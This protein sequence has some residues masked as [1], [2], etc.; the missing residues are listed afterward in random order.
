MNEVEVKAEKGERAYEALLK[1]VFDI[2]TAVLSLKLTQATTMAAIKAGIATQNYS[3]KPG[4][5]TMHDGVVVGDACM[6]AHK[7][8]GDTL[9]EMTA[10]H[11]NGKVVEPFEEVKEFATFVDKITFEFI[12]ELH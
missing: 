11:I 6:V 2:C 10:K 7:L 3:T 5:F 4:L 12:G 9:A 1:M 8:L